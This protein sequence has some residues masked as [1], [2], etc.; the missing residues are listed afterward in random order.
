L[1][2]CARVWFGVPIKLGGVVVEERI[3]LHHLSIHLNLW[4]VKAPAQSAC[5]RWWRRRGHRPG[6]GSTK[7]A[8]ES[9]AMLPEKGVLV[10]IQVSHQL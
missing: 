7:G 4:F 3:H 10:R 5:I 2:L 8:I 1:E 9:A 6:R